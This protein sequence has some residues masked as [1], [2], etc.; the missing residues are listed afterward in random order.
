[1]KVIESLC[2]KY[3]RHKLH[4]LPNLLHIQSFYAVARE[5]SITAAT[6]VGAGTRA[7]LSR[8]IAS[9]ESE[10]NV[11][12]FKKDGDGLSLTQTG[13]DLFL[14]AV[15]I[16]QAAS[17]WAAA[18]ISQQEV[19]KGPV[20]IIA[21]SGIAGMILPDIISGLAGS[22]PGME[23]E[24]I[25]NS[26]SKNLSMHKAD[27]SIHTFAPK[28]SNLFARKLGEMKFGVYASLAY[29]ERRGTPLT[30]LDVADHDL[31]GEDQMSTFQNELLAHGLD[32]SS[33]A[34]RF[35]CDNFLIA[36]RLIVSGCG[37]G[38]TQIRYGDSEPRV[39][40]IFT[41]LP[42]LTLPIWISSHSELK[43]SPRVRVAY[44]L[45]GKE[46]SKAL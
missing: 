23:I 22:E 39:K 13:A 36:W 3:G 28:Q 2:L 1:M 37:I 15:E 18:A 43:T 24:L 33:K 41:E 31:V 21:S 14:H 35:R 27:I 34:F 12:L 16:N 6:A 26:G 19:I 8:H 11:T 5:G 25:V 44:D 29:L 40:R 32:V 9:L 20:R 42:A 38:V 30:V 45:I 4:R 7:T 46:L 10:M 17:G